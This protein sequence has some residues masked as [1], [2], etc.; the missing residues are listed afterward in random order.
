MIVKF[1]IG[2][3]QKHEYHGVKCYIGVSNNNIAILCYEIE[4]III[5]KEQITSSKPKNESVLIEWT[6]KNQK[7]QILLS[8]K[9]SR[10]ATRLFNLV[11]SLQGMM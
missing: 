6:E 9:D 3:S 10:D 11:G 7:H 8:L 4:M 1:Y 5:Q 2:N